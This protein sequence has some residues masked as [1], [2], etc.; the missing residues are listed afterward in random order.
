MASRDYRGELRS[1]VNQLLP[2]YHE[3]YGG[4]PR[5]FIDRID[6][7][8]AEDARW[9]LRAL[10]EG[11]VEI[12]PKTR[13]RLPQSPIKT[14]LVW[15]NAG[16]VSFFIEGALSAGAAARLHFEFGWPVDTLGFESPWK[17]YRRAFDLFAVH[18][19]SM[20][21]LAGEAKTANESVTRVVEEMQA[22]G[23]LGVHEHP[24][25]TSPIVIN[26]HRKWGG[27]LRSK[28]PVFFAFGP[29]EDWQSFL[30]AYDEGVP[31]RFRPVTLDALVFPGLDR[32]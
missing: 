7:L 16:N 29:G 11:I 23:R 3:A 31:V 26:A 17:P 25:P 30:V 28:A 10:D 6:D 14:T 8:S 22:C 5:D 32:G 20:E 18:E 4:K 21:Y 12:L 9:T 13:L 1:R 2:D 27:L 19:G 24:T 15:R